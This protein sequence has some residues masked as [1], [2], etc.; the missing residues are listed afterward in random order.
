MDACIPHEQPEHEVSVSSFYL[1][2]FE[3]TLGRFRAFLD[4]YDGLEM[5]AGDGAHPLIAGSGWDSAWDAYMPEDRS[6]FLAAVRGQFTYFT[7]SAGP[8]EGLPI[9]AV[10]WFEAFAF[11]VWDGGR[12]PT[13]A[14]WEYAAAGGDEN[15]LYPWG[16][17]ST[18]PLPARYS[19]TAARVPVAVGLYP[20]GNGR[21]GHADLAGSVLEWVL[22]SYARDWY[23]TT[24]SGCSDCANLSDD[25]RRVS[26]S[27]SIYVDPPYLRSAWRVDSDSGGRVGHG[28]RCA[29]SP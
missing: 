28:L 16:N 9:A 12:L 5:A 25:T 7:E 26:R 22:D 11:C 19:A 20:G 6:A 2:K 29:R 14:E 15:R 3:V 1:D 24:E 23:T 27:S 21:W 13:E 17:S 18:E 4:A 8:N 10:N